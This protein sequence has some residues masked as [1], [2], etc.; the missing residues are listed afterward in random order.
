MI[1]LNNGN[2]EIQI[3][4]E[5]YHDPETRKNSISYRS[6][7]VRL[8]EV[9]IDEGKND[10]AK[11]IMDLALEKMPIKYFGYYSLLTPFIDGYYRIG[12]KEKAREVFEA[13]CQ[14][15]PKSTGL[16]Q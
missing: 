4:P 3:V 7:M 11:E 15:T 10:K 12:E 13:G 16:F 9:L 6:N 14:K 1:S 2:G 5:I 8:A